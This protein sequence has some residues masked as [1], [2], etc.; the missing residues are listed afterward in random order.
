VPLD[1]WF[2]PV[3]SNGQRDG[4][5]L[6]F[7]IQTDLLGPPPPNVTDVG[8]GDTLLNVHWTPNTDSD[9]GG[10]DVFVDPPP[11]TDAGTSDLVC[12]D[13]SSSGC[14]Q[15]IVQSSPCPS[16]NL[17]SATVQ[18]AGSAVATTTDDAGNLI[19]DAG[20]IIDGGTAGATGGGTSMVL[21]QFL[22]G[23]SCPA[24]SPVFTATNESL[25]GESNSGFTIGG[26]TNGVQYSVAISAVD[27]FGNVGP[28]SPQDPTLCKNQIP[29]PVDDFFKT[30]R[31]AGG[32]G[33][34]FCALDAV[35]MSSGSPLVVLGFGAAVGA[36]AQRRRRRKSTA[37][38][39]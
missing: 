28:P 12:P 13:G 15:R 9:T 24:A 21:C 30:Y 14:F 38:H 16:P 4:T 6:D 36:F 25:A 26:L 5:P 33:S 37:P 27:N 8:T 34:G 29:Q 39:A 18:D 31:L 10:Y 19:D 23:T 17:T 20:N 22:V 1:V 11:G 32:Q 35:G 3:A 2:V 7:P